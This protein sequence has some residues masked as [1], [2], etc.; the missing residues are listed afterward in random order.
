VHQY[1]A[2]ETNNKS[3]EYDLIMSDLKTR[4]S[5]KSINHRL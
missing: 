5:K 3:I 4:R 2:E 1:L